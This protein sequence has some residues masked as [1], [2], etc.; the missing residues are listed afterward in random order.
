MTPELIET[1]AALTALCEELQTQDCIAVDTEFARDRTYF[2]HLGLIQIAGDSHIACIDPLA[3]DARPQLSEL[4]FN[5]SITK[6]FHSCLQDLEVLELA[7]G[8]IPCPL[9]DT[10]LATAL[11]NEDHQISYARLV[12]QELEI[13]LPKSETRTDWLKRPLTKAQLEYAADDV[14]YLLALYRQQLDELDALNRLAWM[15]EECDRLCAKVFNDQAELSRCWTRIKGKERLQGIE[16]AVLQ[17]IASWREQQAI[18]R[19]R[20]RRR[21]L[22]DDLA[23]EIATIQPR[24]SSQ[25]ARI[26]RIGKLLGMS[27]IDSLAEAICSAYD[28]PESEWPAIRRRQLTQDQSAALTRVL[29]L[30]RE[31]AAGLGISQGMLCNRRDAERLVL[32]RRNLQVLNGWRSE[33]I[34]NELLAMLPESR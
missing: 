17:E 29:G 10:Q 9:F 8:D 26:G 18:A 11:M 13:K 4:L 27:A 14:R 19:D 1:P 12:E 16:L 24:N 21:I 25:L 33:F 15:R 2:P 28:K 23:I 7:F 5:D 34:G 32:G 30:L 20:P 22:P 6:V 3:F 31:K